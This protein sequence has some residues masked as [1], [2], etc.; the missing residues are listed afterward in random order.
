MP[1]KVLLKMSIHE[2]EV[3]MKQL[4]QIC[5]TSGVQEKN[6]VEEWM[7]VWWITQH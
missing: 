2:K 4:H 3:I 6:T 7:E 5:W 1:I